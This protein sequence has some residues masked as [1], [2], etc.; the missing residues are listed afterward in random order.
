MMMFKKPMP[1]LQYSLSLLLYMLLP[2]LSHPQIEIRRHSNVIL[3]TWKKV[4]HLMPWHNLSLIQRRF[5]KQLKSHA[6][7]YSNNFW[8]LSTFTSQC[9][10]RFVLHENRKIRWLHCVQS[11]NCYQQYSSIG[12]KT[13]ETGENALRFKLSCV[14]PINQ[15][16]SGVYIG[17]SSLPLQLPVNGFMPQCY[18][19]GICHEVF[20]IVTQFEI[21]IFSD[22]LVYLSTSLQSWHKYDFKYL[23]WMRL[24]LRARFYM[25]GPKCKPMV[26]TDPFES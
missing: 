24:S 14:L 16:S 18:T 3:K 5:I 2:I 19:F 9:L 25:R 4:L 7:G 13:C 8:I 1:W 23:Y 11:R 10:T 12:A 20:H 26:G 6:A 17:G 22:S 15:S 21:F